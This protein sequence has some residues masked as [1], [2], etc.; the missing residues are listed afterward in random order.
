MKYLICYD[1]SCASLQNDRRFPCL[2]RFVVA[3]SKFADSAVRYAID[4]SSDKDSFV[5]VTAIGCGA[6]RGAAPTLCA[7][8]KLID[9]CRTNR[10]E[11][12]ET[13]ST[14]EIDG[15]ELHQRKFDAAKTMLEN[16]FA[17]LRD[18]GVSRVELI[19][20]STDEKRDAVVQ[21]VKDVGANSIVVGPR[22]HSTTQIA[23]GSMSSYLSAYATVPGAPPWSSS[24]SSH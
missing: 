9:R 12:T 21:L 19:I 23:L 14:K 2:F 8:E 17:A 10:T 16:A 24:S 15:D 1:G 11:P 6:R 22:G 7:A 18:A 5:V 13:R 3:G 4:V 20:A